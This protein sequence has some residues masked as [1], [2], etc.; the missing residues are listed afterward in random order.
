MLAWIFIPFFT[1]KPNSSGIGGSMV[2]QT[3]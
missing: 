2:V 1:T 3:P